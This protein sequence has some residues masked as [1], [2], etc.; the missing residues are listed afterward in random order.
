MLNNLKIGVRLGI[1]FAITLTLLITVSVIGVTRINSLNGEVNNMVNDKFPKV[2]MATDIQEA[3]NN[4]ARQLRNA[5]IVKDPAEVQK[6][7]DTV[8]EQRK[9]ISDRLEKLEKVI[10]SEK[11]KE[12]LKAIKEAR[13]HYVVAQDKFIELAKAGKRDEAGAMVTGD[14][15]TTQTAYLKAIQSLNDFQQELME[16]AGKDAEATAKAAE[17]ILIAV[18]TIAT[19]LT[20]AF[21]LLITRSITRP[22]NQALQAAQ[23]LSEGDL[24]VSIDSDSKDEVGMLMAAMKTMI[25]KL[26]QI[27]G[28][29]KG[30]ADALSN[31][32]GQVSATAQSLSQ[33]SSEQAASVEE[34]TASIEQMTA[35]IN[36]N[37]E[38]AKVTDDMATTASTQA[39]EGG[40]AVNQTVD[41]MKQIAGKIGIIDDIAYQTN[42]LALNAAIEAARAG[43]H[44]KGFAVVAAEVRKLAERSQVA[45]QEIGALAGDSVKMA[46]RAGTL[47]NEMVPSIK[48]TSDLVQEI[49]A[50]SQEQ[51]AGVGQINSAM[52]QLNKA[53]QQNASASEEL[54][55][56]AEEM[57]GQS[58]QLQ[59]LMEFFTTDSAKTAGASRNRPAAAAPAARPRPAKL[60]AVSAPEGDFERF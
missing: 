26:G 46:E 7:L 53:T 15:R 54:A 27:I 34:T 14:L 52:G 12:H 10:L 50:A 49:A 44:G 36:Q 47:L 11:G 23:R 6:S 20:I 58:Q 24:T 2:V 32:A 35:S 21:A 39:Q 1:G 41:A 18:A 40:G 45:A 19:I 38:N 31:A 3:I 30:A 33:S 51:S 29:V 17:T 4:I 28:E 55:A 25:G 37:T 8:T 42:L 16:Q 59:E 22:V 43:E 57:G 13:V 5:I 56:T 48:K 9:I 60:A